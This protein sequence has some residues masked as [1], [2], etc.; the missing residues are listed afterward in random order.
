MTPPTVLNDPHAQT[1]DNFP[2]LTSKAAPSPGRNKIKTAGRAP[3]M[4]CGGIR[5][6][7]PPSSPRENEAKNQVTN[8]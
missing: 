8:S 5:P 3:F 7:H 6:Q 4:L 1:A 2:Y